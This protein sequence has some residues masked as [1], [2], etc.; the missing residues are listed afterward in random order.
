MQKKVVIHSAIHRQFGRQH[1]Q[2]IQ[3]TLLHWKDN[4]DQVQTSLKQLD[5]LHAAQ[6][7]AQ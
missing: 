2:M 4:L 6:I 3:Q 7:G 1:W 5:M